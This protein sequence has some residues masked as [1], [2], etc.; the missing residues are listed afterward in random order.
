M[1]EGEGEITL[2]NVKTTVVF[3]LSW[4]GVTLHPVR[5]AKLGA[6]RY[7]AL[8]G[9]DSMVKQVRSPHIS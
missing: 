3:T 9:G 1:Q 6:A 5:R 2:F 8:R 7:F 4:A